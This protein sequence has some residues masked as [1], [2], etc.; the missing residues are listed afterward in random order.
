MHVNV[1]V[2]DGSRSGEDDVTQSFRDALALLP[3][4]GGTLFV[5]A[6][7]YLIGDFIVDKSIVLQGESVWG[8]YCT[9]LQ[10]ADGKNGVIISQDGQ[11]SIIR[12][13]KIE[14]HSG[15]GVT[16]P[17]LD[18]IVLRGAA[19]AKI[20]NVLVT[21]VGGNGIHIDGISPLSCDHWQIENCVTFRCGK[22]GLL[23]EGRDSNAG[24][25][26]A[27]N[28]SSNAEWAVLER[29]SFGNTYV[30]CHTQESGKGS[31]KVQ[32]LHPDT[33]EETGSA[34][35]STFI[36]C[37]TEGGDPADFS[38]APTVLVLG[39]NLAGF[40]D[41]PKGATQRV[42]YLNSKLTFQE[43]TRVGDDQRGV[44]MSVPEVH[45]KGFAPLTF[46]Y[47]PLLN[48][49][50]I[51]DPVLKAWQ[52]DP[53]YSEWA[54]QRHT[55]RLPVDDPK[56]PLADEYDEAPLRLPPSFDRTW[57]VTGFTPRP[58]G[59]DLPVPFGWTERHHKTGGGY[60]FFGEPIVNQRA[61]WTWKQLIALDP[62]TNV[63]H[64]AADF[65]AMWLT[66]DRRGG[67]VSAVFSLEAPDEMDLPSQDG[68]MVYTGMHK[69]PA[70]GRFV[71]QVHNSSN[72]RIDN[73]TLI[74]HFE[75]YRHWDP[76][77]PY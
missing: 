71:V 58:G 13:L 34:N 18:G 75:L 24:L 43:M 11:G 55:S 41:G 2:P 73:I 57:I 77:K 54:L 63:I 50:K 6:G 12:N 32:Q 10:V 65:P 39:G 64:A 45:D 52:D 7:T 51:W 38:N 21:D 8:G 40:A 36:G 16:S 49:L 26:L 70:D 56:N 23:V 25:C 20:E 66:G 44:L 19:V 28:S 60:F 1:A 27:L 35:Y 67:S 5:P 37:F 69:I 62:G 14:P 61:Y 42:G 76:E 47:Q 59:G 30:A 72:N 9:V 53:Y 48:G 68:I 3:P 17:S 22:N 46:H 15:L 31:F 74:A 29:N 33:G 4:C